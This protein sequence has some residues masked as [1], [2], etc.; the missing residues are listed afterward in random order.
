MKIYEDGAGFDVECDVCGSVG[1]LDTLEQA[2]AVRLLHERMEAK[3][4]D[5]WSMEDFFGS[6]PAPRG[7]KHWIVGGGDASVVK[8]WIFTDFANEV[9]GDARLVETIMESGYTRMSRP[10][11]ILRRPS[12]D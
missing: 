9:E 8:K 11:W 7:I 3:L 6:T 1:T 2:R 5:S 12:T 4:I 10:S